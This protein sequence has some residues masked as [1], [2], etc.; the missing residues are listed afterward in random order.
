MRKLYSA[1]DVNQSFSNRKHFQV[2]NS[3]VFPLNSVGHLKP[4]MV[5]NLFFFPKPRPYC[6]LPFYLSRPTMYKRHWSRA[7]IIS[8]TN[9]SNQNTY[10]DHL[11]SHSW[12]SG[13]VKMFNAKKFLAL[14]VAL[15]VLLCLFGVGNNLLAIIN[16]FKFAVNFYGNT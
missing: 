4:N 8:A 6:Y 15:V 10:T 13:W 7:V 2:K 5:N 12:K 11:S 3:S 9:S 16:V 14:V 1:A